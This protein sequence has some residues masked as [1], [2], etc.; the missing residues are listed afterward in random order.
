MTGVNLARFLAFRLLRT[1]L[2]LLGVVALTF[3]L[4]RLTGDPVAL[5]LPQQ[6]TL[7]DYN[8]MRAA[9]GLDQ[10]VAVQFVRYLEGL[11]RGD[12]GRSIIFQRPAAEVVAER[13]PATLALGAPALLLSVVLGVPLG[14]WS[15]YQ[16]NRLLDRL[17]AGL[18]LAGQSLP[19]FAI[20]IVLILVFSVTL[21]WTPTFGSD[22]WRHYILPTITLTLY[23]LAIIIRLTRS[24][25][26]E[27]LNQGYMRTAAA[28]GLSDR[29]RATNHALPNA[30]IPVVTVI[31]LQVAAIISGAA[32]VEAVFAWPGLGT[33]AVG[34]IGGRDYPVI[35]TIVLISAAAFGIANL[36][37]DLAYFAI[38]PRIQ[39]AG[40]G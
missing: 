23:P 39:T 24:S 6:A 20:A 34:S 7:E 12:L 29:F 17:I 2:T 9:L 10:P 33:L 35:Q 11:T 14:M 1:L 15:A 5:M 37:V 25:M 36:L 8:R 22:T 18:S 28:K 16:R 31:G 32:I 40:R 13:I 38:D 21:R 4:G 3:I 30:L 26:L 19:S 27:V